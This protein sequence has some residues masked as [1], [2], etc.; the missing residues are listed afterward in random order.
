MRLEVVKRGAMVA[1]VPALLALILVTPGLMG[2]PTSLS[3]IPAL[4]IGLT[5]SQVVIDIHGAVD[6]YMYR[7]IAI[8]LQGEDNVSFRLLATQRWSYD[9]QVNFSRNATHA[10]DLYVL[11]VDRS[12]NTFALNST[13]FQ[14]R[15]DAGDFISMTDRGTLRTGLSRPPA[16]VRALV[17]RGTAG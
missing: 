16:D 5:E 14:G 9:L 8:A 11:I 12:G 10:I 15:D 4:V 7:N 1:V 17:P 2:R 3:A 6:H 13:V